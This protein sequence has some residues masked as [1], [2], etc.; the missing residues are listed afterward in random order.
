MSVGGEN[1]SALLSGAT[2]V[3][4]GCISHAD[5]NNDYGVYQQVP[6]FIA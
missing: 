3:E 4:S 1:S 2:N 5:M 6:D